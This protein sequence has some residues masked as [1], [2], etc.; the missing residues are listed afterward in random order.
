MI[1]YIADVALALNL[2]YISAKQLMIP[3]IGNQ[4]QNGTLKGRSLFGSVFLKIKTAIQII[5]NEVNVPKLHNSA[6]IFK[7]I[8]NPHTTTIRPA[9]QVIT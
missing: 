2:Q 8:N 7:S 5:I 9:I 1:K 3:K 4:G 6:D